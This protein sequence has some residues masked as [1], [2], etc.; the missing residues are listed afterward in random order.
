MKVKCLRCIHFETTPVMLLIQESS[1]GSL[2]ISLKSEI[3]GSGEFEVIDKL[4]ESE[5]IDTAGEFEVIDNLGE[6][7]VIDTAGEFEVI[8]NLGES[9]VIDR[10]GETLLSERDSLFSIWLD[11]S[12]SCQYYQ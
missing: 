2:S 9:E 10:A 7:E 5:V 6:S 1:S 12:Y 4:G 8:D 3:F 11:K